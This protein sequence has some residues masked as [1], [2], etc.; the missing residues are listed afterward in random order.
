MNSGIYHDRDV[1]ARV[2]FGAFGAVIPCEI[3]MPR[4]QFSLKTMLWLMACAAC[5]AARIA[6]K[7]EMLRR[8]RR[9]IA[10]PA[11]EERTI[12]READGTL[13]EHVRLVPAPDLVLVPDSQAPSIS[14]PSMTEDSPAEEA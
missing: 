2:R 6:F 3:A 13:V 7:T 12:R 14:A 10:P 11:F 4:P 9:A 8:E 1:R 5:F